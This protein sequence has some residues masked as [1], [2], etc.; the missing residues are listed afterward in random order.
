MISSIYRLGQ[1]KTEYELLSELFEDY[2]KVANET[3]CI[4]MQRQISHKILSKESVFIQKIQEI[5]SSSRNIENV[6][7]EYQKLMAFPKCISEDVKKIYEDIAIEFISKDLELEDN[8]KLMING[9]KPF[10]EVYVDNNIHLVNKKIIT[11]LS[12]ASSIVNANFFTKCLFDYLAISKDVDTVISIY[13]KRFDIQTINHT[14]VIKDIIWEESNISTSTIISNIF[15]Y[16][17]LLGDDFIFEVIKNHLLKT[18]NSS[19]ILNQ[20]D[21][22]NEELKNKISD[23]IFSFHNEHPHLIDEEFLRPFC[24]SYFNISHQRITTEYIID[25]IKLYIQNTSKYRE[26]ISFAANSGNAIKQEIENFLISKL[27]PADY[28]QLWEEEICDILPNGYLDNYFDDNEKKYYKAEKWLNNNRLKENDLYLL[29]KNTLLR[30]QNNRNHRCFKTRFLIY[31]FFKKN[32]Y[33]DNYLSI[34]TTEQINLFNWALNPSYIEFNKF[35]ETYILFPDTIQ[36]ILLKYLFSCI[37]LGKYNL[38]ARDLRKLHICHENYQNS[39]DNDKPT[40]CL[41][42]SIIIES[43]ISYEQKKTFI[44]NADLYTL[45]YKSIPKNNKDKKERTFIGAFFDK[46][47]GK[48]KRFFP[49]YSDINKFIFPIKDENENRWYIINFPYD[50]YLIKSVKNIAKIKY[51]PKYKVWFAPESNITQIKEFAEIN[52]FVFLSLDL[53]IKSIGKTFDDIAN[54]YDKKTLKDELM[55]FSELKD[56]EE[57]MPNIT[58]CEGRESQIKEEDDVWWC[59]GNNPCNSCAIQLHSVNDWL[60]YT[61]FDFCKI[62]NFD[63][64]EQNKYGHFKGGQYALFITSINRF[65]NLTERLYCK[66]CGELLYPIDSNYSVNGTSN[67]HCTNEKCKNYQIKIYLN[68]CYNKKCR[69]VIDSR[70]SHKCSNNL[71][72]CKECGTCCSTEMF[73]FRLDKLIKTG[74]PDNILAHLRYKIENNLGHKENNK[75]YCY[76]CGALLEGNVSDTRCKHCNSIIKYKI[77]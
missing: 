5:K 24:R 42:S 54:E 19:S 25:L 55:N 66:E 1:D 3:Q 7:S 51:H 73:R 4:R 37:A 41:S 46:C 53:P 50:P 77:R 11:I 52:N 49:F 22:F 15:I 27:N 23:Y 12:Y 32:N 69:G 44:T 17:K 57:E 36:V 61:L 47:N 76:N 8:I 67:F 72:I 64:H 58:W 29:L 26:A 68:H 20:I 21:K 18:R 39:Y 34:F 10:N 45:L 63:L 9:I 56:W 16:S 70:E 6:I 2:S 33:D 35:C 30:I 59:V 13:N 65:N 60:N 62:L 74:C 31:K 71:V 75:Y 40:M 43:L 38:K 14:K 28:I 48:K